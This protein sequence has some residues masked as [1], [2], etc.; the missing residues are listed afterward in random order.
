M[1]ET[2]STPPLRRD[3]A[4]NRERI[5]SAARE[6]VAERGADI[7]LDDIAVQ[8]G[9]GIAT[10]YRRFPTRADLLDELV[11][12]EL[13][14]CVDAANEA[15]TLSD[16]WKGFEQFVTALCLRHA[17]TRG[18]NELLTMIVADSAPIVAARAQLRAATRR[19]MERAKRSGDLRA[20][21]AETDIPCLLFAVAGLLRTTREAAPDAWRRLL[22]YVLDAY[23]VHDGRR[24]PPRLTDRQ[25]YAAITGRH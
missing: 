14:A 5:L 12:E 1:S 3:A 10:L 16:P 19:L 2:S 17:R 15:L 13:Q 22:S 7:A 11:L 23:R 18:A 21:F 6:L 20:D 9:V 8:A 4:R 24:L 25:L